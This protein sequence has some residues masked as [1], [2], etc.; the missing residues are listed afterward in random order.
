MNKEARDGGAESSGTIGRVRYRASWQ[1]SLPLAVIL[2]AVVLTQLSNP[3]LWAHQRPGLP[4]L[5]FGARVVS[6]VLPLLVALELWV[7]SRYVGVTLTPEAVVVHNLRRRTIPWTHVAE[8]AVEP[9]AGGRRVVLYETDGHRTPLRMPSSG[10]L[11]R[12][13]RFDEKAATI[14]SWWLANRGAARVEDTTGGPEVWGDTHG[15]LP[16]R[17]GMRP[18][19]S[20]SVPTVLLLCWLAADA[21]MAGFAEGPGSAHPTLLSRVLG[22]L[23]AI[24]LLL[25]AGF[26][27]LGRGVVLTADHLVVRGLRPR[28]VPWDEIQ[29]ITVE[30]HR[31]GRRPVVLGADSRRTPLPVPRVGRVLWDSEFEAKIRT[32]GDWWRAH[33][34]TGTTATDAA[35]QPSDQPPL[36]PYGGPRLW[37]K[38]VVALACA[39]LGYEIFLSVVVGALF[40]AVGQ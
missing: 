40:L 6:V 16:E 28:T 15:R 14:R 29:G 24:A 31:G 19:P 3:L 27:S 22:A 11:S 1:Q 21:L 7:L 33:A 30:R 17:L 4:G 26:L 38:G 37:Q 13:R 18:A 35:L 9:F 32:L 5:P 34:E 12:D 23:V 39:V 2:A 36:L 10:F 8:V 20:R 25:G